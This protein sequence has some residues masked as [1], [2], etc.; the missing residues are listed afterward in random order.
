[1]M[2]SNKI[3]TPYDKDMYD[4]LPPYP[5][6]SKPADDKLQGGKNPTN[7]APS[8]KMKEGEYKKSYK[9]LDELKKAREKL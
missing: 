5:K 3:R 6:A 2:K 7:V 4:T 9:S 8:I 1:M